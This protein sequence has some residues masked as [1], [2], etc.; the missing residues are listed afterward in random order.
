MLFQICNLERTNISICN[1]QINDVQTL[2]V[3]FLWIENPDIQSIRIANPNGHIEL[4]FTHFRKS[5]LVA[6]H[7]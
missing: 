6:H 5:A 3:V 1:A 7:K 2:S 4:Y